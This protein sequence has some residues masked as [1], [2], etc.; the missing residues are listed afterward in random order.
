M[1]TILVTGASGLLGK[2]LVLASA[3]QHKIL[4]ADIRE[5]PY[6]V[7]AFGD[8]VQ[9][10]RF[11][12]RDH[13]AIYELFRNNAIDVVVHSGAIS[14]PVYSLTRPVE[15]VQVNFDATVTLLEAA[16]IFHVPKFI[17]M[18][19]GNVY[20]HYLSP[21]VDETHPLPGHSPY[22]VSKVA[23]ELMGRMY[24]REFGLNFIALRVNSIYGPDRREPSMMKTLVEAA[25]AGKPVDM[26]RGADTW[27]STIYQG[28]VAAPIL[29]CI[30]GSVR[31][32]AYNLND[33]TPHR[34][35]E[36]VEILKALRPQWQVSVGPGPKEPSKCPPDVK[37]YPDA[38]LSI[39]KARRDLGFSPGFTLE[40]GVKAWLSAL[41]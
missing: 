22:G 36:V 7:E 11:D 13:G 16:R 31:S 20:G 10:C 18:S 24:A 40:Q 3:G 35:G 17:F 9:Q 6:P 37:E 34:I 38:V 28:D 41:S 21:I 5:L 26:P 19:T 15:T 23:A 14:H 39:E 33:G 32:E 4:A 1:A 8:N 29:A 27:L 2:Q 12:L 25:A 30:E